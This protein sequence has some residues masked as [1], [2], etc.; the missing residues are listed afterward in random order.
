MNSMVFVNKA[1]QTELAA[2]MSTAFACGSVASAEQ[3]I[4]LNAMAAVLTGGA[5]VQVG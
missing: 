4:E 1:F 3:G 5:S 2:A